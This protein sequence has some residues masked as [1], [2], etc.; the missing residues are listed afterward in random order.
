MDKIYIKNLEFIGNHGV[1]PEEK[2]LQQKFII[3]VEMETSTRKAGVDDDLNHSTHYGFVAEDIEKVF[4]S[5]SF[6][7]IEAL[8]ENIA[9]TILIKYSL[10]KNVKV[11]VKKP[12]APIKK[13][14]DFV[15]IEIYRSRNIA[16]LSIGSNIG[17]LKENLKNAISAI[18]T[19]ENTTI[20]KTSTFLETKPFGNIEQDNFLNACLEITTLST[21]QELLKELLNIENILGRTREIKW[22]PRVIDLDILLFNDLIVQDE[23][24]AIPH[25]WMC[26]RSFVLDPLNE[27][28]PNLIHP[29]EKKYISRLKRDLYKSL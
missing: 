26:E 7:L 10:I 23:N 16:Y 24:L 3:S 27:I 19:L 20:T 6:D 13:H 25:P 2:F 4:F 12:W 14:F 15:A 9:K 29:L 28:A 5:Q 21:P 8:A 17:N 11:I 1:F 18:S 22:G